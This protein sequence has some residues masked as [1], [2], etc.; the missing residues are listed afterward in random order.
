M[1]L[2]ISIFGLGYVGVVTAACLA[3]DGHRI[4]GVDV[5]AHKVD[6]LNAAQSPIIEEHIEDLIRAGR[7]SGHLTATTD[8][9]QAIAESDIVIICVGTPSASNGS[10][11]TRF[12]ESVLDQIGP[13]LARR[14]QPLP[15][16]LRSTMLPGT[17]RSLVVP[18]LEKATGA[19]AGQRFEA[20]FHPEFLREGTSVADFYDPP[21]IVVGER[22]PGTGDLLLS[23]Y[24]GFKA[25]VFRVTYEAA[26]MVKYCDNIFHALKIT[27]A[28]EIGQFCQSLGIDSRGVMDVFCAD[29]KLNISSKYLRPGFA[30]GGSCL[31]KDLRAFLHAARQRDV[32]TPML[33]GILPSNKGQIE[34]AAEK[35][36]ATGVRKVGMWGLAFKPGTDDLRESP[37]VALAEILNGKGIDLSIYDEFVQVTRLV[38]GNKAFIEQTLPHLA[39][40]LV[41]EPAVLRGCPSIII[42]HPA[43]R[44]QLDAWLEA[45]TKIF[46]LTGQK[47]APV[48][49]NFSSLS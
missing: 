36:L 11:S 34:S 7:K 39:R 42:G 22:I 19:P 20:I 25:P 4:I 30:F 49:P 28:N 40:L 38:G 37:L 44:T 43:T 29:T 48:H 33:A 18:R 10:L 3:K 27:F 35:I 47:T 8:T 13:L 1:P 31:P 15:I 24:E 26:E 21:K 14:N 16:V 32:S 6:L 9:A 17:M 45:G 2:T 5:S 41:S 46:D 23:L 12:I